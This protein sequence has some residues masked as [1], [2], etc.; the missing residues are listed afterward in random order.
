VFE[1]KRKAREKK[2]GGSAPKGPV[3]RRRKAVRE[4]EAFWKA[5][6][7]DAKAKGVGPLDADGNPVEEAPTPVREPPAR[8]RERCEHPQLQKAREETEILLR[9]HGDERSRMLVVILRAV[10]R[11][12]D[13]DDQ[14]LLE[15]LCKLAKAQGVVPVRFGPD[16]WKEFDVW[17]LGQTRAAVDDGITLRD[18]ASAVA[19]AIVFRAP[20]GAARTD[21][22]LQKWDEVK[23]R[24]PCIDQ[25]GH[26]PKNDDR[27]LVALLTAAYRASCIDSDTHDDPFGDVK[28]K[29]Q[30]RVSQ[31]GKIRK[32]V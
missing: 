11:A 31:K 12:A 4:H 9:N 29:Q 8:L 5:V 18:L 23:A 19:V 6:V 2:N 30:L 21:V 20:S 13:S 17:L 16:E 3:D 27:V 1:T 22:I 32:R 25:N 26:V 28:D 15:D 7:A 24:C 10:E 14:S